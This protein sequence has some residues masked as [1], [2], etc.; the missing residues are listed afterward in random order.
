MKRLWRRPKALVF[1][2]SLASTLALAALTAPGQAAAQGFYPPY[3]YYP[4]QPIIRSE[5]ESELEPGISRRDVAAILAR[6]GYR[7]VGPLQDHGDRIVASGV[8][9]RGRMARFV[10]DPDEGEILRSWP[11]SP[12]FGHGGPDEGF[13]VPE[14]YEPVE[15]GDL[16][17]YG[18]P[19][20]HVHARRNEGG[21]PDRYARGPQAARHADETLTASRHAKLAMHSAGNPARRGGPHPSASR[22]TKV[23]PVTAAAFPPPARPAQAPPGQVRAVIGPPAKTSTSPAPIQTITAPPSSA[24]SS[25]RASAPKLSSPMSPAEQPPTLEIENEAVP[26]SNIGK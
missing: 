20:G 4:P 7:L 25:A 19:E 12:A 1:W 18:P 11:V 3:G 17:S 5:P 21:S 13:A 22:A 2:M 8:D 15:K 26:K 6:H 10:V 14:P 16:G 9:A 24:H 23:R